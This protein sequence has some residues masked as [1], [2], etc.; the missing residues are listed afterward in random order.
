VLA[1]E[2]SPVTTLH[3]STTTLCSH[4]LHQLPYTN[5]HTLCL[6]LVA[7]VLYTQILHSRVSA[8]RYIL[9]YS[10]DESLRPASLRAST[11]FFRGCPLFWTRYIQHVRSHIS[12]AD[13]K[14]FIRATTANPFLLS[15][16]R[17]ILGF[18]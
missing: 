6:V 8:N 9:L 17:F 13:Y 15:Y 14:F 12:F 16:N 1:D 2:A 10:L 7:V 11:V 3:Y 4:I 5:C 18:L